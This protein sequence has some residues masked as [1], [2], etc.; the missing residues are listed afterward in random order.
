MILVAAIQRNRIFIQRRHLFPVFFPRKMA[1]M[2]PPGIC[3]APLEAMRNEFF[4]DH[5]SFASFQ[6]FI[7][8]AVDGFLWNTYLL[9]HDSFDK[10]QPDRIHQPRLKRR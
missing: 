3:F 6:I 1:F 4:F 8:N 5:K 2:Q 7:D 9:G 10:L